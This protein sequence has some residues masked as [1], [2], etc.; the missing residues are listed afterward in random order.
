VLLPFAGGSW[1][2]KLLFIFSYKPRGGG[3]AYRFGE[4][5]GEA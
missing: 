4:G 3:L 1:V 5:Y 2:I